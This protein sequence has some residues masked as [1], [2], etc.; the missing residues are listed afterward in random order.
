MID[1]KMREYF[2]SIG[3][4]GGTKTKKLY[5]I[6]HF[7]RIALEQNAKKLSTGKPLA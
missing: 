3:K 6:S 1:E 5:G 4:K 2:R 7:K